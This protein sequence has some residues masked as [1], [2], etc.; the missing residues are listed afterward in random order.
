[1]GRLFYKGI[2]VEQGQSYGLKQSM[3]RQQLGKLGDCK[4][5]RTD[6]MKQRPARTKQ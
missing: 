4:G 2:Y 6:C 3:A 1:M 5:E